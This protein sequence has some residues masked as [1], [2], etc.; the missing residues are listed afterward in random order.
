MAT[1]RKRRTAARKGPTLNPFVHAAAK[2]AKA[3][4]DA[5]RAARRIE[6]AKANAEATAATIEAIREAKAAPAAAPATEAT[7]VPLLRPKRGTGTETAHAPAVEAVEDAPAGRARGMAHRLELRAA[8]SAAAA[9][10]ALHRSAPWQAGSGAASGARS[11]IEAVTGHALDAVEGPRRSTPGRL[12]ERTALKAR[13]A[14]ALRVGRAVRTTA[15]R[16]SAQGG[17]KPLGSRRRKLGR[18]VEPALYA[19]AVLG[20]AWV[21][22]RASDAPVLPGVAAIL[23]AGEM[24][25]GKIHLTAQGALTRET[26]GPYRYDSLMRGTTYAAATWFA[27]PCGLFPDLMGPSRW[28]ILIG[29]AAAAAAARIVR[30]VSR[31]DYTAVTEVVPSTPGDGSDEAYSAIARQIWN[32]AVACPDTLM[33]GSTITDIRWSGAG[34]FRALVECV[35]EQDTVSLYS[36]V[37]AIARAY[38]VGPRMIEVIET[39]DPMRPE[40]CITLENALKASVPWAPKPL[41]AATGMVDIGTYLDGTRASFRYLLPGGGAA[42]GAFCGGTRSGKTA[43]LSGVIA[44]VMGAGLVV[45]DLIDLGEVSLPEWST[46]AFRFG[47]T[48]DDAYIALKRACAVIESRRKRMKQ[49]HRKTQEGLTTKGVSKL[50]ISTDDPS[51]LLII[52]EAPA[53]ALLSDKK[54]F[55]EIQAMLDLI[56][57][58]GAKFAVN[59]WWVS[60]SASLAH[61]W[62][63]M[64]DLRQNLT[65][66]LVVGL[67][68]RQGA[69]TMA[70]GGGLDVDLSKIPAGMGGMGYVGGCEGN[71]VTMF[72]GDWLEDA[73]VDGRSTLPKDVH[74]PE[75]AAAQYV[76][77]HLH[78]DDLAAVDAVEAE[79][80]RGGFYDQGRPGAEWLPQVDAKRAPVTAVR[81]TA[82]TGAQILDVEGEELTDEDGQEQIDTAMRVFLD[83][84]SEGT[85]VKL[86]KFAAAMATEL[87]VE[88]PGVDPSAW[89]KH[90]REMRTWLTTDP[91]VAPT[92][93]NGAFV[94]SGA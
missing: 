17:N 81:V 86:G 55:K 18:A 6:I 23:T 93:R 78:P 83:I 42:H 89:G 88:A 33:S 65:T 91:R 56:G 32:Q 16:I 9:R 31:G 36:S 90:Y 34:T 68:A 61:G 82:S 44:R 30:S 70:F 13:H 79:L 28:P 46:R 76:P 10:D 15:T 66:G 1:A 3:K 49:M 25:R 47:E 22:T 87:G 24:W 27:L 40:I 75:W 20:A 43:T 45:L 51:Y 84:Y 94:P 29:A 92:D 59:L 52:E 58:Q 2:K 73:P 14:A 48:P 41:D 85:V 69:S 63:N 21:V 26:K 19:P 62:L 74:S 53:L 5:E 57:K 54:R 39:D 11:R 72:R 7:V 12:V 80:G 8:H 35:G 37:R 71:R 60:Q 50:P 67:K 64:A 4:A 77:G 38:R